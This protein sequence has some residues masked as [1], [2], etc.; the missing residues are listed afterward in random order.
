MGSTKGVVKGDGKEDGGSPCEAENKLDRGNV[1]GVSGCNSVVAVVV[2]DVLD[3]ENGRDSESDDRG[4][5]T[6]SEPAKI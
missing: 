1:R 5:R 3:D 4:G 6:T 2:V